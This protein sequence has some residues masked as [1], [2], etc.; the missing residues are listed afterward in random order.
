MD[1][2]YF[3][4]SGGIAGASFGLMAAAP[5]FLQSF[6]NAAVS[7]DV[8]GRKK[9]MV[10][11]F[12]RGAV[13][14][15]NMIIPHGEPDY[16]SSR[17]SIAIRKPGQ[18]G[19]AIDLDGF[20]GLHPRMNSLEAFGRRKGLQL[21]ILSVRRIIPDRISMPKITWNPERR[22]SKELETAG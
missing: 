13:D 20:F 5:G 6:A 12:Q 15:L 4:R 3:L 1:R 9:V 7:S 22:A 10:T 19:G 16:Y 21:S 2:R 18:E 17:R 14:G 8:Y 11:I